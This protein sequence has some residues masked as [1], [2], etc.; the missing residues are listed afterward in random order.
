MF[1]LRRKAPLAKEGGISLTAKLVLPPHLR[2]GIRLHQQTL[3]NYIFTILF[4]FFTCTHIYTAFS[5]YH[6]CVKYGLYQSTFILWQIIIKV[7]MAVKYI[8][9]SI[10]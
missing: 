5:S 3:S 6:T 8:E 7:I 1:F 2:R 9:N 4:D 10:L